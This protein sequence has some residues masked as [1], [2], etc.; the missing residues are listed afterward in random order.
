MSLETYACNTKHIHYKLGGAAR[1]IH[2]SLKISL[3]QPNVKHSK[4]TIMVL[5]QSIWDSRTGG[6][7]NQY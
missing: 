5:F 7:A 1:L 3:W 6:N 4:Q 2:Q